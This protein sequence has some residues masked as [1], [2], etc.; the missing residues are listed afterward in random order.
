MLRQGS[1]LPSVKSQ[2][3]YASN[4]EQ[5]SIL[6]SVQC[7]TLLPAWQTQKYLACVSRQEIKWTAVNFF[8]SCCYEN[9]SNKLWRSSYLSTI[10]IFLRRSAVFLRGKKEKKPLGFFPVVVDIFLLIQFQKHTVEQLSFFFPTYLGS[11]LSS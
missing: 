3:P 4:P 1:W 11:T 6:F 5:V 2:L 7:I 9:V 10:Y 8:R